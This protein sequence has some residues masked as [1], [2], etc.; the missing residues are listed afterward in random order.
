MTVWLF[1]QLCPLT[2]SDEESE[3]QQMPWKSEN[4]GLF[5]FEV[6]QQATTVLNGYQSDLLQPELQGT[7]NLRGLQE[8]ERSGKCLSWCHGY[9]LRP[10][11]A[12]FPSSWILLLMLE[13]RSYA[14]DLPYSTYCIMS[15]SSHPKWPHNTRKQVV[16]L[17]KN[18]Y[19]MLWPLQQVF[20]GLVIWWISP[21]FFMA[22]SNRERRIRFVLRLYNN[23]FYTS[24]IK[25]AVS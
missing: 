23:S 24:F 22:P 21:W 12:A 3:F 19:S 15:M 1:W 6:Q 14:K 5:G 13:T 18:A 4:Q 8:K 17:D 9:L 16:F 2:F 11:S 10:P 20:A 25:T 7:N